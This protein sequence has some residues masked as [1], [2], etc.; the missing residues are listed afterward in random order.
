MTYE[1]HGRLTKQDLVWQYQ[2]DVVISQAAPVQ[3]TWYNIMSAVKNVKII[4]IAVK[5][6]TADETLQLRINTDGQTN[7]PERAATAGGWYYL[8]NDQSAEAWNLSATAYYVPS[9]LEA[10]TIT[11]DIRK[12]TA[13]GAGTISVRVKYYKIP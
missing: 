11:L 8:S 9:V 7:T 3:N 6:A 5:V 12:T 10:R 1:R 2:A 4:S 13:L